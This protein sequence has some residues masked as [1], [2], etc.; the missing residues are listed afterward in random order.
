V[1]VVSLALHVV[2]GLRICAT[3][4]PRL[5]VDEKNVEIGRWSARL[6]ELAGM[7]LRP[8]GSPAAWPERTM[9]VTNHIS[10]I[11]VFAVLAVAPGV[12][13]AKSEIRGWPVVGKLVTAVDTL[14]IERERRSDVRRM[15]ENIASAL[16]SGRRVAIC[17]EGTTTWGHELL[18]FHA[19]LFQPAIDADAVLHPVAIRYLDH[20]GNATRAPGYVGEMT[21]LDSVWRIVS[22]HRIV[23][24]LHFAEAL[25]AGGADRRA[26]AKTSH[27]RIR[28]ALGITPV[29]QEPAPADAPRG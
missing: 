12:F 23:V 18:R 21:L 17:P 4:F 16:S 5:T 24:E 9:I 20:D 22:E 6:L 26:L 3:R 29:A 10:W 8:V 2:R 13:V 7:E 11:D 27:D 15:N 19:A 28:A 25:P 1:R 14:F